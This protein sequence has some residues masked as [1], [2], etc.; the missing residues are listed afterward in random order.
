MMSVSVN[1]YIMYQNTLRTLDHG[2]SIWGHRKALNYALHL[3]GCDEDCEC[4]V[5]VPYPILFR[6][7]VVNAFLSK[8]VSH[9]TVTRFHSSFGPKDYV[10]KGTRMKRSAFRETGLSCTQH[11][12]SLSQKIIWCNSSSLVISSFESCV[13]FLKESEVMLF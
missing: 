9:T 7:Y 2:S 3:D 1:W 12:F 13:H 8:S 5:N 10:R 6:W 11:I 4:R